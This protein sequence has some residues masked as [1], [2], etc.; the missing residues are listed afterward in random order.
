[1]EQQNDE[2]SF[3]Q[4]LEELRWHI[5]RSGIAIVLIAIVAFF[6]KSFIFDTVIFGPKD[7]NF[8][9]FQLLCDFSHFL[10]S[11]VPDLVI[12]D[13]VLCIGQSFP[14]LQNINMSGQ[15]TTHIMV[16]M[17]AG[18][19][20]GF[21]YVFWE[22]WRFVKPGLRKEEQ[23]YTRGIV[24]W[25]WMLFVS[26]ILFGYYIISPLSVNF[27]F[28]YSISDDVQTIPTLS[29]YISTVVTIVLACGFVFELPILVFFLT[30]AGLITPSF[31][32]TYRKHA[33]VAALVLSAVITPPDI[34]SQ[35]LVTFPL[36]ILYEIS[37]VISR[38]VTNKEMNR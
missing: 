35:L 6:N 31:L 38:T 26:G 18:L 3:L 34:F 1:M 7:E 23:R 16:S 17:I 24:F 28:N 25:T 8:I 2:M 5:I 30:K 22:F 20:V 27:F 21:P 19:V 36:I 9:T 12:S 29:T 32:K 13:D 15:F 14:P 10:F 11:I 4:H 33:L 37:I